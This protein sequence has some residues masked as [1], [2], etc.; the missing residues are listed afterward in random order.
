MVDLVTLAER[1][2]KE[3]VC[4]ARVVLVGLE[5]LRRVGGMVR[6]REGDGGVLRALVLVVL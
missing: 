5:A 4:W 1:E 6:G 3:R 2:L